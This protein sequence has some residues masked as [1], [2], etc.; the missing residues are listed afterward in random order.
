MPDNCPN[1][2]T[3]MIS[4][5]KKILF[6]WCLPFPEISYLRFFYFLRRTL[7]NIFNIPQNCS[8]LPF[9]RNQRREGISQQTIYSKSIKQINSPLI[10]FPNGMMSW[11][12]KQYSDI[13]EMHNSSWIMKVLD[14]SMFNLLCSMKFIMPSIS[15]IYGIKLLKF[16]FKMM[17]Y[18]L[19]VLILIKIYLKICCCQYLSL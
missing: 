4:I 14:Y 7:E 12:T 9:R 16:I 17:E 11:W 13:R 15:G 5:K 6:Y 19:R 1:L 8:A 18:S 3:G 10:S 2:G